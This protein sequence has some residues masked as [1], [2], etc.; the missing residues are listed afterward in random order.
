MTRV[1]ER[2]RHVPLDDGQWIEGIFVV[3]LTSYKCVTT[4]PKVHGVA[5]GR[6]NYMLY[7]MGEGHGH[8]AINNLIEETETCH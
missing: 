6:S 1:P 7:I 8:E 5:T 2:H 3:V 4:L